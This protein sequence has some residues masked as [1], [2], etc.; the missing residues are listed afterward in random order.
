MRIKTDNPDDHVGEVEEGLGEPLALELRNVTVGYGS[1]LILRQLSLSVSS[2]QTLAL[3][4]PNG[5]GKTTLLRAIAG[6]L[7]VQQGSMQMSGRDCTRV[8]AYRRSLDGLC[9]V[10]EGR[11]IFPSLSVQENIAM[12]ARKWSKKEAIELATSAFSILG[13]RLKQVAGTLSGGEQRMLALAA[14]YVRGTSLVLIDE[15]SLGLAPRVVD[16]V[17]DFIDVLARSGSSLVL[18]DQFVTRTLAVAQ[19]AI[20]LRQGGVVYNGQASTLRETDV[21]EHFVGR[22]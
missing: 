13:K 17:F 3:I 18:V 15:A 5:A 20:V 22:S 2:G 21:F 16:E 9:Y 11:G 1:T 8:P 6:L 12:Q 10:P 14:A 19:T 7:P 4:G